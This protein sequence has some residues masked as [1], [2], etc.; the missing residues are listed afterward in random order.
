MDSPPSCSSR[1]SAILHHASSVARRVFTRRALARLLST[2]ICSVIIAIR[3]FSRFGGQYAFLVLALKELVFSVQ[4]TLAQQLELTCLNILGALLGI[5]VSTLAKYLASLLGPDTVQARSLCAV[6]LILISFVG[7]FFES[8]T[9]FESETAATFA[10]LKECLSSSLYRVGARETRMEVSYYRQLHNQLLRRSILLNESYS[11][12]AFELRVGRLSLQSIHPF[13]GVVEHL[14]RELA[15]GLAPVKPLRSSPGTPRSPLTGTVPG[16]PRLPGSAAASIRDYFSRPNHALP[17]V[18]VIEPP[19]LELATAILEAMD[20]VQR[21]ITLTFENP[22]ASVVSSRHSQEDLHAVSGSHKAAVR[23]AER[24]LGAARDNMREV[25]RHVFDQVDM[26]QRAEGRKAHLPKEIFDCSLAAIALLQMTQEMGKALQVARQVATLYEE[27]RTRLWHPRISLQWLGVPPGPFISDDSGDLVFN[28]GIDD[29]TGANGETDERLTMLEVQQG[30]AEHAYS[31]TLHK[32]KPLP[33]GGLSAARYKVYAATSLSKMELRLNDA[34]VWSWRFWSGSVGRLWASERMLRFRVW[35]SKRYRAFQHSS[36]WKHGLKYA[37]GTVIAAV[38]AYVTAIICKNNPYGIVAMV[39]AFDIP[40]SWIILNT[41]VA[42]MGCPASVTLPPIVFAHYVNPALTTSALKLSIVRAVMI[43]A[44]IVAAVLVNSLL[45]PRHCRVLFLSDTSRT[46]GRLSSLYLTLSHD[47]FRVHRTRMQE[48][49]RKTLKLE[50]QIRSSL[51][52]LSAVLKTMNDELSLLPKPLRHYREI[53]V[54]LQ[55]LLDLMTGLRK[56]RENIPRKETV[57]NVF[58]ER[59]E[60][61]SCVCI[62]LY[63]CQ[64]A[65]RAREPLPQ[66]LPSA[67][68]AFANL[69]SHVQDCISEAR[70]QEASAL[71]LSLVYAFAEQEVMQNLVDTLEELLELT[72]RWRMATIMVGIVL[73]K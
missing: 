72:V 33:A 23:A 14:R 48:D 49:R 43:A 62:T 70:A 24:K 45:F 60:F 53:V 11:Q 54:V 69:E 61:M 39:T 63:A 8:S 3:P 36:H 46:L 12:A 50:L 66:F 44:G 10:L 19:A 15:W 1:I 2:F 27:S 34:R 58:K 32:G 47:M 56:I 73:G 65:F 52:R 42:P 71:G 22:Y 13:V 68:H 16:T 7:L 30:L 57:A 5:G 4:E 17:F 21:L 64:H 51:Y 25:L 28:A 29:G 37:F 67:R 31:F 35:L 18:S 26:Q 9:S 20:T 38:Y 6:F 59:R 55:K 41:S 40:I